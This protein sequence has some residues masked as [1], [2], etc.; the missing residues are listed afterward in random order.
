MTSL[1]R[2]A[3]KTV[4]MYGMAYLLKGVFDRNTWKE[5]HEPEG[6]E[7]IRWTE[8]EI[9]KRGFTLKL[10]DRINKLEKWTS[11]RMHIRTYRRVVIS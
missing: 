4:R 6:F 3:D 10:T 8:E 9:M 2:I 1:S 11:L 5:K 7:Y